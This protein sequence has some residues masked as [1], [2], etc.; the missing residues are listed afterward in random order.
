MRENII[1]PATVTFSRK[2]RK[3]RRTSNANYAIAGV[4]AGYARQRA[5]RLTGDKD[6]KTISQK[7][8]KHIKCALG[9]HYLALSRS[10]LQGAGF[11]HYICKRKDGTD[12]PHPVGASNWKVPPSQGPCMGGSNNNRSTAH[13]CQSVASVPSVFHWTQR[14]A[15]RNNALRLTKQRPS[16]H[17]KT[18]TQRMNRT[19]HVHRQNSNRGALAVWGYK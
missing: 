2:G 17:K 1:H 12:P 8:D 15:S 11:K 13:Q 9:A 4:V 19:Y 16:P 10:I 18:K 6:D 5:Q 7:D 3:G 14:P